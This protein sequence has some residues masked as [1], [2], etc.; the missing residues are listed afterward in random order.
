MQTIFLLSSK[1]RFVVFCLVI[2]IIAT[3]SDDIHVLW[4]YIESL[5]T[6]LD[7]K[8]HDQAIVAVAYDTRFDLFF[9]IT[10]KQQLKS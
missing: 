6:K 1:I 9:K 2:I 7:V 4:K 5:F 8:L 10:K 3:T